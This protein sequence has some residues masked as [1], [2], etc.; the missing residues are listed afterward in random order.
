MALWDLAND[1]D[2]STGA[3]VAAAFACGIFPWACI[4][5]DVGEEGTARAREEARTIVYGEAGGEGGILGGLERAG[6]TA[7]E[8]LTA[9]AEA[10]KWGAIALGVALLGVILA[11]IVWFVALPLMGLGGPR[12]VFA[13][14]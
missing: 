7:A 9:A 1:S 5:Q 2:A 3:R 4:A 12:G 8:P 11:L 13:R 10:L 6:R 14:G